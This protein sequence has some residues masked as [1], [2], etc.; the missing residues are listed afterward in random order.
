MATGTSI[1]KSVKILD[2]STIRFR[3]HTGAWV[4]GEVCGT[5]PYKLE[6]RLPNGTHTVALFLNFPKEP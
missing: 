3:D 1:S 6:V 4:E 5:D 2:G